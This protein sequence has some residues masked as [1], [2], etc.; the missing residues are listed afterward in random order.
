MKIALVAVIDSFLES[1]VGFSNELYR[2][3]VTVGTA[4]WIT[5]QGESGHA[6]GSYSQT[7]I[8][9]K[10]D[11]YNP[12]PQ[13]NRNKNILRRRGQSS[14]IS[15]DTIYENAVLGVHCGGAAS[16]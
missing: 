13:Y 15:P 9:M 10:D 11:P 8:L 2:L 6:R 1:I 16:P 3:A 4:G 14:S 7:R 5:V 12:V